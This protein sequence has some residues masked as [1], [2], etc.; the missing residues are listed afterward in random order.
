MDRHEVVDLVEYI[1]WLLHDFVCFDG[2]NNR[3]A[4]VSSCWKPEG[5]QRIRYVEFDTKGF[6][7]HASRVNNPK[8]VPVRIWCDWLQRLVVGDTA[9][10]HML[11]GQRRWFVHQDAAAVY[12]RTEAY[13]RPRGFVNRLGMRIVGR[14]KQTEVWKEYFENINHEVLKEF[15][16]SGTIGFSVPQE[17]P[18]NPWEP[19]QPYPGCVPATVPRRPL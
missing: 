4:T 9:E 18:G 1:N 6:F 12:V 19:S 16:A 11:I 8:F 5:G 13:E 3:V 10:K 7:G 14:T 2:Q 17:K 15:N